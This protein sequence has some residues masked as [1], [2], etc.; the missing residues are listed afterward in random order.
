MQRPAQST[1]E[2]LKQAGSQF[3]TDNCPRL[4][5]ALGY[6][7]VFS[8]PPLLVITVTLLGYFYDPAQIRDYLAEQTGGAIGAEQIQTMVESARDSGSGTIATIV[9]IL[10][11]LIG[12]TAVV[13][14][15]Q[16][17]MNTVWQVQPDKEHG[18]VKRLLIKRVLSFGMILGI[19]FLLLV[20]LVLSAVVSALGQSVSGNVGGDFWPPVFQALNF[21]VS[22]GVVTLLFA[23]MYK[24]LPD[25]EV[26]WRDVWIGA[27]LTAVLFA[28]GKLALGIYFAQANPGSTYGA[29]GSIALILIWVYY[30]AMIFFFGAEF[31]QAF[32]RYRGHRIVPSDGAVRVVRVT[33]P[34]TNPL[35]E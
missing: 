7:T 4:A 6:Y 29:A 12:A 15:L 28:L 31:T 23:A 30:S 21:V 9:G 25:A 24:I 5:A 14:Q 35:A 11:L 32:A 22:L 16:D 26:E 19:A 3:S 27:F 13:A 18:G 34:G 8:L 17:A 2:V 10:G 33:Q 1:F 20:S